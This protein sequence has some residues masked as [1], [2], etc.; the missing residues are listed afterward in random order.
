MFFLDNQVCFPTLEKFD[1]VT[2]DA[3]GHYFLVVLNIKA[4]RFEVFDSLARNG[5]PL[6][7][8]ACHLLVDGI[9]TMW[10]RIF[11]DSKVQIA[12][13][14]IE[15]IDSPKQTNGYIFF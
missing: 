6:M 10:A 9:K 1:G 12:N 14:P 8:E 3:S 2:N 5:Q 7:V 4:C 15:V 13:W 11:T